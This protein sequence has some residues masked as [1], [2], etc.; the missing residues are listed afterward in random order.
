MLKD[1]GSSDLLMGQT[2]SGQSSF[3]FGGDFFLGVDLIG[4]EVFFVGFLAIIIFLLGY[5][6]YSTK[7]RKVNVYI[8]TDCDHTD[9]SC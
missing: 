2:P 1:S 8:S 5:E 3:V 9:Q 6:Y 4:L 7:S